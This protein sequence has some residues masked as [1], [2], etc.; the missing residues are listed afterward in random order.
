MVNL[1][2]QVTESQR[3]GLGNLTAASF[4]GG[5]GPDSSGRYLVRQFGIVTIDG[6]RVAVA[7]AVEPR[8]GSFGSGTAAL[9]TIARWLGTQRFPGP[10]HCG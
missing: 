7:I 10:G 4:K 8:D 3:W 9:S 2:G 6:K 5:W 1:M